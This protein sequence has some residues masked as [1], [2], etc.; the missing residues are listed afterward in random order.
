MNASIFRSWPE[1]SIIICSGLTSTIR[2]RKIS[3]SPWISAR[4]LGRRIDLDEHQVTLDEV[5]A[6]DVEDL[7]DRDDLLQLLPHLLQ[8]PVVT[9]HDDRDP[10]KMR[11]FGLAHG[12]T[13]DVE[14]ARR[15]H[16]RDVR[17]HARLVLHQRRENVTHPSCS[18]VRRT[19]VTA[20]RPPFARAGSPVL[21]CRCADQQGPTYFT[22]PLPRLQG[23]TR[24]PMDTR[25][26][27]L[28]S[29]GDGHGWGILKLG[30]PGGIPC[31]P[32]IP[33]G[34]AGFSP[35]A[36]KSA[37]RSSAIERKLCRE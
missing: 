4:Q 14:P 26:A 23:T 35:F 12:E 20:H 8:M 3:T 6:R 19:V 30:M 11:V 13:V 32:G 18:W 17:Q 21:P 5:L 22:V 33:P 16:P 27:V 34:E 10:G 37:A 29:K 15:E 24:S 7:D 1:I 28:G 9:H 25:R 31:I 36:L 2:P